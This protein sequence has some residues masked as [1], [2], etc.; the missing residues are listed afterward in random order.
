MTPAQKRALEK[1]KRQQ[2]SN[3]T[4]GQQAKSSRDSRAR[5]DKTA[6]GQNK[7]SPLNK[8]L[9]EQRKGSKQKRDKIGRFA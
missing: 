6:K 4:K 2:K 5:L 3:K 9:R 7:N 8:T 1:V